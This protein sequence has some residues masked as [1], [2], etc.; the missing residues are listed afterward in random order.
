MGRGARTRRTRTSTGTTTI[1]RGFGAART[2]GRER[3]SRG[4]RSA[5]LA[6]PGMILVVALAGAVLARRLVR[7]RLARLPTAAGPAARVADPLAAFLDPLR[8]DVVVA[9]LG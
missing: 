7:M 9:R 3:R 8:L 5:M 1:R 6:R 4:R 2:G